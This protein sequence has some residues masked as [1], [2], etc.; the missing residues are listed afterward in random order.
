[1]V[2]ESIIGPLKAE[3]NYWS[4]ILVGFLYGTVG[5]FLSYWI[6]Q[7]Q[8][9][10]VMVFFV[11]IAAVPLFYRTMRREESKIGVLKNETA[12][13]MSHASVLRFFM[14]FFWD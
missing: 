7:D 14:F 5:L 2:L 3:K 4:L 13:L 6:F 11:V 1:M 10:I 8:A 12:L 9:G